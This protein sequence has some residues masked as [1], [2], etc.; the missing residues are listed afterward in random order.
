VAK[1]TYRSVLIAGGDGIGFVSP[2]LSAAVFLPANP[3]ITPFQLM[4]IPFSPSRL[5]ASA[6]ALLVA[7]IQTS[8]AQVLSVFENLLFE[9]NFQSYHLDAG[10]TTPGT[11][12]EGTGPWATAAHTGP[13]TWRIVED[14]AG[15]FQQGAVYRYLEVRSTNLLAKER[16]SP[17]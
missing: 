17:G 16:R 8:S 3:G 9:E 2:F 4:K 6:G 10:Q 14:T 12:G 11:L 7:L 1:R 15:I 13:G 5:S